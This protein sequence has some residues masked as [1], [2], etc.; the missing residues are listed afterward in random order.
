[1]SNFISML[2]FVTQSPWIDVGAEIVPLTS[3]ASVKTMPLN[4]YTVLLL[5]CDTWE[6]CCS[7]TSFWHLTKLV[8][9][10]AVSVGAG[11]SKSH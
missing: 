9:A 1:M 2:N 10:E 11:M 3:L 7:N 8:P 4:W 6:I 5:D